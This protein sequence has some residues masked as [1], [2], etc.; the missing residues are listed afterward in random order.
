MWSSAPTWIIEGLSLLLL[1]E[2][3]KKTPLQVW[4]AGE[5]LRLSSFCQR[6][7]AILDQQQIRKDGIG[8]QEAFGSEP[9]AAA[10]APEGI[11]PVTALHQCFLDG[12]KGQKEL[13][14]GNQLG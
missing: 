14:L 3:H 11:A 9:P 2:L 1:I 10:L 6:L 8:K 7:A 4:S 5:I 12:I 13:L